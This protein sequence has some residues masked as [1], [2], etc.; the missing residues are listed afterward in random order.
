MALAIWP[1]VNEFSG[2]TSKGYT[3]VAIILGLHLLLACGFMLC[4]FHV[5]SNSSSVIIAADSAAHKNVTMAANRVEEIKSNTIN[6]DKREIIKND[7]EKE[8]AIQ[9]KKV[10]VNKEAD[11]ESKTQEANNQDLDEENI[12]TKASVKKALDENIKVA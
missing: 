9:L 2:N 11:N 12:T 10:L 7:N 8:K 5:P 4:F 6:E 1:I 3:L